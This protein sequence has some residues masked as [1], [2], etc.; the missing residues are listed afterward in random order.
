MILIGVENGK[1]A[2]CVSIN[3]D[4]LQPAK[5]MYPQML[6]Q[7]QIGEENIGWTYNQDGSFSPP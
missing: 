7:E 2:L 3:L 4:Q 1:V 6:L 5:E